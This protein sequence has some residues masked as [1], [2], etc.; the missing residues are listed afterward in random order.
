[1]APALLNRAGMIDPIF[2]TDNYQLARKLLDV[3]VLR[4]Q[5]IATNIANVETPGFRRLDIAPDFAT[6]LKSR[7]EGGDFA[8]TNDTLKPRLAEDQNA[9]SIR[10]DGNTV[11]LQHEL[12][13]MDRN[14]VDYDYSAQVVSYNLKQLRM[15]ITGHSIA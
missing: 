12:V 5:A 6:Q 1:V 9:R 11:E 10:M 4:Q 7:M 2:Q 15:A 8:R 14:A 3:A 13:A